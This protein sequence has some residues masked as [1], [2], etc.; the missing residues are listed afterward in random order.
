MKKPYFGAQGSGVNF[1]TRVVQ[2]G[3]RFDKITGALSVP[4]Y[5]SATF[6]HPSLGAST[7]YDYTRTG[8]PTRQAAEEIIADLEG[9]DSA[10]CFSS[11]LAALTAVLMIFQKG[12]HIIL[13]EDL[14]GG[15]YRLIDKIFA[16][17]GINASYV[18]TTNT[19]EILNAIKNETKALIYESLSNP[20]LMISDVSKIAEICRTKNILSIVD[21]TLLTPYVLRPIGLGCD[22]VVH[23]ATKYLGGHN[24]ILAGVVAT[25]NKELSDRIALVQNACGSVLAPFECW[26]LMRGLKTLALRMDKQLANAQAVADWLKIQKQVEAVYYPGIGAMISFR[27]KSYET[28]KHVLENVKIFSFAESLG[29]VESLITYPLLQTHAD[30]PENTKKKL[31][32]DDK[33]L[34]ISVGIENIEDLLNDLKNALG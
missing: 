18:D 8:N 11:G 9:A 6:A 2:S 10:F 14:Y 27:L 25:A 22:I 31:G 30:V 28:L 23:S 33:L 19:D 13:G 34:R 12:D 26:L 15:T 29:G 32:I 1:E 24:D 16:G 21:N 17:F 7:G 4:I 20:M 3:I 5:Q